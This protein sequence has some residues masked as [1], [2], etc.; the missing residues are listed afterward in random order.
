MIER[1]VSVSAEGRVSAAPDRAAITAGVQT[2][3]ATAKEAMAS[4]NAA[5]AKVID[6]L[7]ALGIQARD[8]QTTALQVNP[9][10]SNPTG[11][12]APTINGYTA[13]NQI[14]IIVQDLKRLGE[15]LDQAIALGANQMGGIQFDV[16][17]AETLKDEARKQA[18]A[19]ARRRAELYAAAAGAILGDVLMISENANVMQPQVY[20]GARVSMAAAVPVESGSMELSTTAHVTWALK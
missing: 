8:I 9:R 1:S 19:N 7:K 17:K 4:N 12:R 18:M 16:S 2:E 5:I 14:H 20:A 6:G 3:A 13:V 10:Y 11:N 15:V